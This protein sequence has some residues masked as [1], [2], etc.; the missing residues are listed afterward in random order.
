MPPPPSTVCSTSVAA[1]V[2]GQIPNDAIAKR[3]AR[4]DPTRRSTFDELIA[5]LDEHLK[6]IIGKMGNKIS[7]LKASSVVS[8]DDEDDKWCRWVDDHL[9]H[10]LSPNI[11]LNTSEALESFDYSASNVKQ[12]LH[13]NSY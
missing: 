4:K 6:S 12:N 13:Q 7:P 11:Y 1:F 8:Y 5:Q 9:V 3:H 2:L 10:M